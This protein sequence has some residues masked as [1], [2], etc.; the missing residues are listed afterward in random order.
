MGLMNSFNV[1]DR[2][3]IVDE[4]DSYPFSLPDKM[5]FTLFVVSEDPIV[6]TCTGKPYQGGEVVNLPIM[7]NI[8]NPILLSE[9]T[10]I[11]TGSYTVY[12]GTAY[13]EQ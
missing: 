2:I 4:I 1:T 3:S 11:P 9:L 12:Y 8:W 5:P 10:T 13:A 7:T 6:I